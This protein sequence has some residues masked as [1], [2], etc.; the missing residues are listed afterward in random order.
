MYNKDKLL[1]E[2]DM[3]NLWVRVQPALLGSIVILILGSWSNLSQGTLPGENEFNTT[4]IA[5][6]TLGK[7]R[8]IGPDLAGVADRRT[9]E[10]LMRFIKSSQ[11]MIQEGD[12]EAVALA[13]EYPGLLMPDA[14]MSDSQ[15]KDIIIFLKATGTAT[16]TVSELPTNVESTQEAPLLSIETIEQDILIGQALFQGKRRFIN[17][18]VACNACHDVRNDTVIGG[19]I[20]A[21]ELTTVFSKMGREGVR[22]IIGQAPFPIMQAA[23]QDK[24]LAPD[25]VRVLVAFL[26]FTDQKG[27][28]KLPRDYGIGLFFSGTIGAGILFGLF[29]FLWR[30]RKVGSVNQAI[31]DRQT[32]SQMD[33]PNE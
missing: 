20:L 17:D 8:L 14:M 7:G 26:E 25:E 24:P 9:Q 23:Y 29:G 21:A 18:G 5:C 32:N 22:A 3:N 31:Y 30:N 12:I 2:G 27:Y 28:N 16:V 33:A 1:K 6:H 4:C 11:T 15:I 10:W 19:G 13:E